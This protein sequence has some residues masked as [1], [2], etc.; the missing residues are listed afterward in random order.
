M[1][2][3]ELLCHGICTSGELKDEFRLK[4]REMCSL[5]FAQLH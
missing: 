2:K 5:L 1:N 4:R 3:I